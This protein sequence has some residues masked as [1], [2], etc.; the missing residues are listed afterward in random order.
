LNK[1]RIALLAAMLLFVASFFLTAVNN[2]NEPNASGVP[3]Y[4]CA[5]MA[6]EVPWGPVGANMLSNEP[7]KFLAILLSGWINPIFLI[8]MI[9]LL[10]KRTRRLGAFLRIVVL[11]ILPSCWIVF[12]SE[13]IRPRAGYFL[14]TIAIVMALFSSSLVHR[15]SLEVEPARA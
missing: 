7:L 12:S 9:L 4:L 2:I 14:W 11:I 5:F 3:G 8:A 15:N 1:H 10:W 6:I 13:R